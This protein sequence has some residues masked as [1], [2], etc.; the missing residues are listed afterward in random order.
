MFG[1]GLPEFAVLALVALFVFG[2]DRLPEVARQAGRFVRQA[3]DFATN[4]KS[5][6][7]QEFPELANIDLKDL[8]ARS[9]I[10]KHLL[11]DL[12][13][14]APKR[15]GHRPLDKGEKPPFDVDAT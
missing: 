1:I 6:M 8:N 11:D 2:P 4:A 3:R 12:E 14:D 7:A 15:P 5:Q 10:Q 13:D 9:L